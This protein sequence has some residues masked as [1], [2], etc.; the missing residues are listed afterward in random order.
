MIMLAVICLIIVAALGLTFFV[1]KIRTL[2][3]LEREFLDKARQEVRAE[4]Q[5]TAVQTAQWLSGRTAAHDEWLR[6]VAAVAG[7]ITIIAG[8]IFAWYQFQATLRVNAE[9]THTN[10][11]GV[12]AER[13]RT[14]IAGLGDE[15]ES[16]RVG[17]ILLLE[18]VSKDDPQ[19]YADIIIEI[20]AS[21]VR[22]R[23]SRE[24]GVEARGKSLQWPPQDVRTALSVLGRR[25]GIEPGKRPQ[26]LPDLRGVYLVGADLSGLPLK[27]LR[28]EDALL[29][30]ADLT[31]AD[32]S[33]SLF[34]RAHLEEARLYN[35]T[36]I[37]SSFENALMIESS[38]SLARAQ[39]ALLS[40]AQLQGAL[41]LRTDFASAN[42]SG[43]NLNGAEFLTQPQL[44]NASGNGSTILPPSLRRPAKWPK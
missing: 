10:Q 42:I 2:H 12:V 4:P 16:V 37:Q 40:G 32:L 44:E 17:N 36:L 28:F 39:Q 27:G 8:I 15:D 26:Q 30:E 5:V 13:L 35:A 9:Q 14:G 21:F 31:E 11:R 23:A 34:N 18:Q 43:T 20:I 38:L 41:M 3:R 22:R 7:S 6:N 1:W 25:A 19:L 29:T 24:L 33:Y